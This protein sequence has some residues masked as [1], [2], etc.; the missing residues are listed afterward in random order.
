MHS[1]NNT[2]CGFNELNSVF[3]GVP[4]Y[5]NIV[6]LYCLILP[7]YIEHVITTPDVSGYLQT[8]EVTLTCELHGYQSSLSPPVWLNT[9][10]SEITTSTKYTITSDEG[11]KTIVFENG[12]AIPSLIVSLTIRNLSSADG[13]NYTCRGVRGGESVTQLMIAEGTAPP[14]TPPPITTA[15]PLTTQRTLAP[16]N[17]LLPTVHGLVSIVTI[18]VIALLLLIVFIVYLLR[19]KINKIIHSLIRSTEAVQVPNSLSIQEREDTSISVQDVTYEE[20]TERS[21]MSLTKNEAYV[22]VSTPLEK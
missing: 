6:V 8:G 4:R 5:V 10:G 11:S 14:T 13:G 7:Y 19:K 12:T 2:R 15:Q 9:N 16:N 18:L 17:V 20:I 3:S 22:C 1:N 21:V